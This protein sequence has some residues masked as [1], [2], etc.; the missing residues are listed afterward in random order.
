M[1]VGVNARCSCK[2]FI[3]V[4][5]AGDLAERRG[6]ALQPSPWQTLRLMA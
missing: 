5:G 4:G 1:S 2:Q 3:T 6:R